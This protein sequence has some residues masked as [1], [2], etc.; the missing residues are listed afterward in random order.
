VDRFGHRQPVEALRK[1]DRDT[2]VGDAQRAENLLRHFP[3]Q[4]LG[5]VHQVVVVLISLVELE[6]RELGVVPRRDAFVAEVP[7]DL[8]HLLHAADDEPLEIELGRDPQ[9]EL[10][11]ER[12]VVRAERAGRGAAGDRVH[13]RRLDFEIAAA[14]EEFADRLHDLRAPLEHFP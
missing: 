11:V 4:R 13:H 1:V 14:D 6:H 3:D 8:E 9:K 7:V 12:V 5:E 10:H 2:L